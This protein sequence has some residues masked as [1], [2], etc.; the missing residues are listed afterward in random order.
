MAAVTPFKGIYLSSNG[1]IS[2]RS[3]TEQYTPSGAQSL[4]KIKYSAVAPGDYRHFYLGLNSFIMGYDYT[5]TVVSVGPDS[6]FSVGDEV[7]GMGMPADKRPLP[8]GSHQA[9]RLADPYL[10]WRRPATLD[11]LSAVGLTSGIQTASDMIVNLFNIGFPQAG[12]DG[13]SATGKAILIWGGASAVGWTAVQ[14][15]KAAG[16]AHILTTAS[17]KNHAALKEVGATHVFDYHSPSVVDEIRDTVQ[18]LDVELR[19]GLD[20]VTVGTGIFDGLSE[21]EQAEVDK[22]FEE[23]SPAVMKRALEGSGEI[24]VAATLPVPRDP[25]YMFTIFSRR[26][27]GEEKAHPGWWQ[28]QEKVVTWFIENHETTWRPQPVEVVTRAEEA[29][30]AIKDS[31]GGKYSNLKVVLKHP[32]E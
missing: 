11:P 2:I 10:T 14:L 29:V 18:E 31:F 8:T 27:E 4:I 25:D 28:R 3:I 12:V 13:E 26:W 20:A 1:E 21:A 15:A 9:Y 24:K 22:R 7:F 17:L 23:S 30:A 16:F 32:L 6:P 5:G 19:L